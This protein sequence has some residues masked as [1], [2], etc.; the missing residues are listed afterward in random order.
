MTLWFIFVFAL[1]I[2]VVVGGIIAAVVLAVA[3]S[4]RDSQSPVITAPAR[5]VTK[6]QEF[7]SSGS[8]PST[9]H[10]ATFELENGGRLEFAMDAPVYGQLAEG[11]FGQLSF[12]GSRL[13]W[14]Q[15]QFGIA[16]PT[17]LR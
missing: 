10:F 9:R 3:K 14:F 15:R 17:D 4:R 13:L 2:F 1:L 6:R 5:L 11:D 16:P 8:M 7:S 12:Q